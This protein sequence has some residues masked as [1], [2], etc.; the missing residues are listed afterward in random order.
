MNSARELFLGDTEAPEVLLGQVETAIAGVFADIANDVRKLQGVAEC[1]G[2]VL[3]GG[4]LV[5][6]NLDVDEGDDAGD[7]VKVSQQVVVCFITGVGE[8]KGDAID[9]LDEKL[10]RNGVTLNNGFE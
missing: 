10:S 1:H 5:A 4:I 3:A 7:L 8:V 2:V 9:D 6:K